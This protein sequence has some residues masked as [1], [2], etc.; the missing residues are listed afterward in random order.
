MTAAI[1]SPSWAEAVAGLEPITLDTLNVEAALQTRVDRKYVVSAAEW[2]AVFASLHGDYR[3]L[4]Q[5][6]RRSFGYE[7]DY[8]DTVD[9]ASYHAAARRR[10][11]RY[12]VRTRHYVDAG[13]SAIEVK[14]HS[15]RGETVK[16]REFLP[17]DAARSSGL[18]FE[19][20]AFVGSFH[21]IGCDVE[22]LEK[23]LTTSY[24]RTTLTGESSRI[25]IDSAVS[26]RQP[27]GAQTG[28]GDALIVETKSASRA[29]DV[30]RALWAHGIRPP[31]VSK[32][33][34]SLA[35][36]RPELP[37]NRW[38]RTL[39]R[40]LPDATAATATY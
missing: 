20:R 30:D 13:L 16:H 15:A 22:V 2:A 33:C 14:L 40:H 5:H 31:R 23:V 32:Y 1:V 19:A 17:Q 11:R 9:L 26:A 3:V 29:G 4:E 34:T 18:S 38:A 39:R 24:E 8:Y 25:T 35:A 28:F 36:L 37:A 27:R 6:G 21:E 12:K 7:S 10:P